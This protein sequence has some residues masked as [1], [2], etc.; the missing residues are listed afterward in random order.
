MDTYERTALSNGA[1]LIAGVDEAGRGP[2]AGPVVAAAVIFRPPWPVEAG[3]NDS[4][5]L[6]EVRRLKLYRFIYANAT[7]VGVGVV[8]HAEIDKINIHKAS[9]KAM[10]IAVSALKSTPDYLLIDG[11]FKT[12]CGISELA[13]VKGDSLSLSIAAASIVAK[14]VRDAIMRAYGSIYPLYGFSGHKGYGSA[15][16]M[17]AIKEYGPCPVHRM[18]YRPMSELPR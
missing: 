2:L 10:S 15:A 18:S 14:T 12:G 11:R 4:K 13:I 8:W 1:R 9:L 5:K 6:S 17:K 3:I 7:S 16:H